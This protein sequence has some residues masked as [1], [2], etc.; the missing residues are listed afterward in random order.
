MS[1]PSQETANNPPTSGTKQSLP[2]RLAS[3]L[4][5]KYFVTLFFYLKV[6]TI[7]R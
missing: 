3:N 2:Q 1:A 7:V 5:L 4:N 6:A